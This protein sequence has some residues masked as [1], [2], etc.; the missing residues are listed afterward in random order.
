MTTHVLETVE[1]LCDDVAIIKSGHIA[2][3]GDVG[4][5]ASGGKLEFDGRQFNTLEALFLSL[6]G[7]KYGRLDW[8]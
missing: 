7:E 1:R 5:L 8:L 3:R 6:V 4:R 2:W